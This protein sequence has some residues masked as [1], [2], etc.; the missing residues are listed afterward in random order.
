MEAGKILVAEPFAAVIAHERAGMPSLE[1]CNLGLGL[2]LVLLVPLNIF[3]RLILVVLEP[4]DGA[5]DCTDSLASRRHHSQQAGGGFSRPP[6]FLTAIS[7]LSFSKPIS[8]RVSRS[9]GILG[10]WLMALCCLWVMLLLR[11]RLEVDGVN[12]GVSNKGDTR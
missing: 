3:Q 11:P 4:L 12:G 7:A 10:G 2:V 1:L 9:E 6:D 8:S 5:L